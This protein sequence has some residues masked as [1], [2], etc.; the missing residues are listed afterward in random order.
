VDGNYSMTIPKTGRYVVRAELAAFAPVT[1]EVRLTAEAANGTAEFAL[2]LASRAAATQAAVTASAGGGGVGASGYRGRTAARQ[3]NGTQALGVETTE[4]GLEDATTAGTAASAEA[5]T[6]LLG[7]LGEGDS[8]AVQG[9][10]GVTNAIGGMNEDQLRQTIQDR[11]Q[12][13]GAQGGATSDQINAVVSLLGPMMGFGGP[14]GGG[15]GGGGPGGGGRG[16]PGGG[17]GGRGGAFRNFNPAQPH[18][19]IFYQGGNNALN[20]APWQP[21]LIAQVNPAAYQNRFGLSIAGTP[22]IPGLTKPDTRQFMFINLTGQKNLNAFAPL[23]VRVPTAAERMGDFSNSYQVIPGTNNQLEHVTIYNP[24]TGQPFQN[25]QIPMCSTTITQ[26]CI[27]PQAMNL[28]NNYYPLP[29]I[30]AL[31]T[32]PTVLNYQTISNAGSNNVAIN[33]RYQRQLGQQTAGGPF[34]GRGG[35]GGRG[36]RQNAN[37]PPVLRQNINAS[38]NFSHSASDNRNIFLPLGGRTASDGNALN[39]GYVVSY[40]RLSNNASINYNR[41]NAETSNYFTDTANN[42]V[43][44]TG[45]SIPNQASN[46]ADPRFYNGLPTIQISQFQ[47]LSTFTP[48]ETINQTIAFSDF[49][50]WRH[51]KHNFRFGG[52]IRRVHNDVI[53]GNNPLGS[54]SFTGYASESQADQVSGKSSVNSGDAVADLLMG[55]P[56]TTGIQA[57]TYKDYLRENVYDW[58]AVDDF[59]VKTNVTLNYSLRYEYFGPYSEKNDHLVNLDHNGD[60]SA[61]DVVK[62]GQPSTYGGTYPRSLVNPDYAMYAPRI[63]IAY[64]PKYKWTK[65]MVIRGGYGV[66]YNT[67]QY[68][69]FAQ[70]L[71]RQVPFSVTQNN[72]VPVPTVTTPAPSATGCVTTQS[73][74][75][76]TP[77]ATAS[78][79]NPQPIT[80]AAT[81]ANQTLQNGFNCSTAL[82]INNNWAVDKN[83]RLG[84]V[85][86]FNLNIQKTIGPAIVLN[87]GYNGSKGSNLDVVG[88]PNATASVSSKI[89]YAA[90]FDYEESAAGAHSNSLVVSVQQR[91]RKGVSLG[92]TYTYLHSIDNASGVGG[93][94]GTPVQNFYRLDLEEGNSSFDQRHNLTGTWLIE[95][96]FGPNREYLNKGGVVAKVL[97]GFS[98]SGNFTFATGNYFTPTYSGNQSEATA[99][100]TFNQRPNRDYTQSAVGPGKVK[101]FFNT[102][103]FSAPASGQYGTASQGSI[104]GPGTTAVS[105]A[106]SRT[107]QLGGTNSFEARVQATNVFN[108]VQ[109]ASINTTENS[110]QFGQVTSAAAMRS[111]LFVA[112]YRF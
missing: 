57:G 100:N 27:T 61:V 34:G 82:A 81:I 46:F 66:N 41:N 49:V 88:T 52:D 16:G 111:L 85:Q 51:K 65:N 9:Q 3:G 40:G 78:N 32:D 31:S 76:F 26:A 36:Q 87:V 42:P 11:M 62:P 90:P 60:F 59:R 109:Y 53:G 77:T 91:Q 68:A 97:D 63:G 72:T 93:A 19:S 69:T 112:R 70:K 99:A 64:S 98:I 24:V 43:S 39:L 108:T 84:N 7:G 4:T 38:Y 14:G 80:R 44:A 79:P 15:P 83:Y 95:L 25:N 56:Q 48:S 29:N 5:T 71:S 110:S 20:S 13:V 105:A 107:V 75:T 18:G 58:Y 28:L 30:N 101:Q 17:G 94:V 21:S 50:A 73:Q 1:H 47:G 8:V 35:G 86:I 6:P 22:Y 55:L 103:A 104:E 45:I 23:P 96:P 106:L 74:Y 92:A 54:F 37:A 12:Q 2:E 10:Q 33:T 89:P 102:A 67:G